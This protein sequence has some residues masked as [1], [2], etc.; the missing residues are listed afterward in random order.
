LPG[1]LTE[2]PA[3]AAGTAIA[4]KHIIGRRH[5]RMNTSP[6]GLFISTCWG[7]PEILAR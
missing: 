6:S 1:E 5:F 2:T 7:I 3:N 4:K